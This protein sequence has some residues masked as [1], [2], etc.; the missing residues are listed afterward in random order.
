MGQPPRNGSNVV[1]DNV[2]I[3][4]QESPHHDRYTTIVTL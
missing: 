2:T 4:M 1:L 3:V